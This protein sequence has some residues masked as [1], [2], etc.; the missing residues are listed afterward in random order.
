VFATTRLVCGIMPGRQKN[1]FRH[2]SLKVPRGVVLCIYTH[3]MGLDPR[4]CCVLIVHEETAPIGTDS[5]SISG[6]CGC[7]C[8]CRFNVT[9]VVP[10]LPIECI[11]L[12]KTGPC[13][14]CELCRLLAEIARMPA[15]SDL[16]HIYCAGMIVIQRGYLV[17]DYCNPIFK[18][19][20]KST[21]TSNPLKVE[22]I[23]YDKF[24]SFVKRHLLAKTLQMFRCGVHFPKHANQDI[25][26]NMTPTKRRGLRSDSETAAAHPASENSA[27]VSLVV[28]TPA[29]AARLLQENAVVNSSCGVDNR[30]I[31]VIVTRNTCSKHRAI[32]HGVH[33]R[34]LSSDGMTYMDVWAVAR[35]VVWAAN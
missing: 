19:L 6:A 30:I 7:D 23:L 2:L 9:Q 35:A 34:L 16:T 28:S 22:G 25:V 33:Q 4:T 10:I 13:G 15:M 1:Y 5:V 31:P 11:E 14:R 32:S 18:G 26:C 20:F 8:V 12:G 29:F 24:G 21:A 27:G 17:P 3:N